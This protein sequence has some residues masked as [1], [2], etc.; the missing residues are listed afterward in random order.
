MIA[1]CW[2]NQSVCRHVLTATYLTDSGPELR[3]E[4]TDAIVKYLLEA[5]QDKDGIQTR[6]DVLLQHLDTDPPWK[7]EHL[8]GTIETIVAHLEENNASEHALTVLAR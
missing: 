4:L 1:V 6:M 8:T 5:S 2:K 3:T 7:D